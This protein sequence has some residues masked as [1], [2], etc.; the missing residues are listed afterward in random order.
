MNFLFLK[1]ERI[2]D[3]NL[4][5][6]VFQIIL[7][8]NFLKAK[9]FISSQNLKIR[10]S[11]NFTFSC[12]KNLWKKVTS[13]ISSFRN[14]VVVPLLPKWKNSFKRSSS[15]RKFNGSYSNTNPYSWVISIGRISCLK[16]LHIFALL[17]YTTLTIDSL[18]IVVKDI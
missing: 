17:S 11:I 13:I 6:S 14:A 10:A 18:Y 15:S 4:F 1:F 2:N 7:F 3:G 5:S 8:R 16:L 12:N 9:V